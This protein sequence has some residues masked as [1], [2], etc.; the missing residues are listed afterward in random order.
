MANTSSPR[1]KRKPPTK[2]AA[3]PRRPSAGSVRYREALLGMRAS[4]HA[5]VAEAIDEVWD[6]APEQFAT[7]RGRSAGREA[8]ALFD[9]IA[10]ALASSIYA[11]A[12]P[13]CEA[14]LAANVARLL[15]SKVEAMSCRGSA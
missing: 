12:R 3:A 6:D 8:Q 1:R 9:G 10:S 15:V 2:T 14:E 4:V 7:Y 11:S 5:N 13:G